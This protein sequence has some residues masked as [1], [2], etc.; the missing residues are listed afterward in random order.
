MHLDIETKAKV[1]YF[2]IK[3]KNKKNPHAMIALVY[4]FPPFHICDEIQKYCL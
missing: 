3:N 4:T 1:L 2:N